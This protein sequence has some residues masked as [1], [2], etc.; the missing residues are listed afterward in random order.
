MYKVELT[1]E[2]IE[3]IIKCL[4]I[5]YNEDNSV[6]DLQTKLMCEIYPIV[7]TYS[8]ERKKK[9]KQSINRTQF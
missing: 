5:H 8:K 3:T 1:K 6:L 9:L 7:K 4:G 2:E